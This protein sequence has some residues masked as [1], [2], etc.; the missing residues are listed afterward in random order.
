MQVQENLCSSLARHQRI[1]T[2]RKRAERDYSMGIEQL[3]TIEIEGCDGFSANIR[4]TIKRA[5]RLRHG[6][7]R[8]RR[9]VAE[10]PTIQING[11]R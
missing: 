11:S 1:G 5:G 7:Y 2:R 4:R 6:G 9:F 8:G 10:N 3:P